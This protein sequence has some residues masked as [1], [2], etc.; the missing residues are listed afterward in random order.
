ME[1]EASSDRDLWP[2]FDKD[3]SRGMR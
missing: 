1:P 3:L 2:C